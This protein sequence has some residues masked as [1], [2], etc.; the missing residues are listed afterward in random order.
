VP[1]FTDEDCRAVVQVGAF[2]HGNLFKHIYVYKIFL[3]TNVRMTSLVI[4]GS[5]PIV[6]T[7]GAKDHRNELADNIV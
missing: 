7:I 6:I 1:S 4:G 3:K 5:S 2:G